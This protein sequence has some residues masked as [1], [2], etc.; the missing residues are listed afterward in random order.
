MNNSLDSLALIRSLLAKKAEVDLRRSLIDRKAIEDR[1]S[2]IEAKRQWILD[3]RADI[4]KAMQSSSM[5]R[6][7]ALACLFDDCLSDKESACR[8][9]IC[10]IEKSLLSISQECASHRLALAK[11]V[12]KAGVTEKIIDQRRKAESM[13]LAYRDFSDVIGASIQTSVRIPD[14]LSGK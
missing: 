2:E 1:L 4:Q 10:T 8:F 13:R 12:A 3:R 7:S 9:E 14:T 11:Q 6:I 5:A